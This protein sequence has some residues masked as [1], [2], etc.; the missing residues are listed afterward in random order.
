M[1]STYM[2]G[3]ATIRKQH[4][5]KECTYTYML[6]STQLAKYIDIP[7]RRSLIAATVEMLWLETKHLSMAGTCQK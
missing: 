5:S 6:L 1:K 4:N 2:I 3:R 7:C